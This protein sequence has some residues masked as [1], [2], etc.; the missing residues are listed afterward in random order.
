MVKFTRLLRGVK[1]VAHE[2]EKSIERAA[3]L[4]RRGQRVVVFTGA[5]VSTESGIP[6]FRSPGGIWSKYDPE[7]FTYQR[8]VSSAEARKKHWQMLRDTFLSYQAEP[9]AAHYAIAALDRMGKLDCVITQN[10]DGLHQRAG[11]PPEKVFEL[12]GTMDW[13]YCLAC[14]QRYPMDE[15]KGWLAAG[16][17][18][19]ECGTCGGTLKPAV[20]YFGE[21]LPSAVLAEAKERSQ[22]CDVFIVVGSSLVVYPAAYLPEEALWSGAKL[23]IVNLTRTHLDG[24]AEVVLQGKAGEVMTA[25]VARLG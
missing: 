3:D 1:P 20:V 8:F 18:V 10:I 15:V 22:N 12:H 14:R 16:V 4:V 19:P 2:W 9:N 5:G 24:R 23:I 17:E 11:V 21:S 13:A 6:D 25:L 7:E